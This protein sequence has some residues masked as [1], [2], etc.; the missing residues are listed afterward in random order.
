M[1]KSALF[2]LKYS[3]RDFSKKK[4]WGK[5]QFNSSFP[6]SLAIYL[7]S[8]KLK[9]VYIKLNSKMNTHLE[10]IETNEL[11]GIDCLSD[12]VFFSFESVYSPFQQLLI[13]DTPRV[14]LVV[15]K[16]SDSTI[17]KGLEIKLTALPDNTTCD[18]LESNFGCEIVIRPDTIVYL[19]CSIA[20]NYKNDPSKLKRL[21]T[22]EIGEIED[23]SEAENILPHIA[24]MLK[25]IN[26]ICLDNISNQEPLIM[27]PIWKTKGKK[28]QLA[29]SCLD[30]FVWSN[31]AFISLFTNGINTNQETTRVT[32]QIRTLVWLTKMLFDF[33]LTGQIDHQSIIDE[34]SFN[35]KNDKAF[36][37]SG[38][39]THPFM[40]GNVLTTPRIK[41]EEIK[42]IILNGGQNMLSPERR[43]DA[44]ICNT[45]NLFK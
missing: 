28:A 11:F 8:K 1:N 32:R 3:N 18:Q 39:I 30:V 12:D 35:T 25:T 23:W 7:Q 42:N 40:K 10:F 45:P 36:A 15:Q 37:A 38:T 24:L 31:L 21:F 27:Q 4:C 33:S 43:F 5:N 9:N 41:K 22:K 13:G 19:A 16:R 2:G 17:I 34:L 44:I 26:K 6:T 14:D 29:D 20:Q